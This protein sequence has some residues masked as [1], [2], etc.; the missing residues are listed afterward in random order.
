MATSG[1]NQVEPISQVN[2]STRK[3]ELDI[4]K[5]KKADEEGER[6]KDGKEDPLEL[7]PSRVE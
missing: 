3:R 5:M 7:D 4:K 6:E 1:V 2:E